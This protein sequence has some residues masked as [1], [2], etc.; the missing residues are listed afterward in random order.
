[1]MNYNVRR[2]FVKIVTK[3]F[4]HTRSWTIR[5]L[6]FMQGWYQKLF[7]GKKLWR[8]TEVFFPSRWV[9]QLCLVQKDEL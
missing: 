7:S 4:P 6:Y 1:M 8:I 3:K 5:E 2:F 9:Q